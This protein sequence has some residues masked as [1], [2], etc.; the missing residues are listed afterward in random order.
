MKSTFRV[1][2]GKRLLKLSKCPGAKSTDDVA[3]RFE[4]PVGGE[5][6]MSLSKVYIIGFGNYAMTS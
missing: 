3:T 4:V 2:R 5:G 1:G 6:E